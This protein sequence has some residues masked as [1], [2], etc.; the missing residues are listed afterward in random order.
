MVKI[1]AITFDI[2]TTLT[3]GTSWTIITKKLGAPVKTHEFIYQELKDNKISY[4]QAKGQLLNLWKATGNNNKDFFTKIFR[5]IPL[6]KGAQEIITYLKTKGII[7]CLIT[8]SVDLYAETIAK[9]LGIDHYF[10]NTELVWD[11]NN[12]LVDFHYDINQSAKKLQ[13]F[14]HFLSQQKIN[15]NDCFIVGDDEN[16]IDLFK[17]TKK[18]IA[19]KSEKIDR[20]K[21]YAWKVINNLLDIKKIV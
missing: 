5:N 1:K 19:V 3:Y 4:Q 12:K 20:L 16:D 6:K 18:G 11:K 15:T 17:F 21:P 13:Q 2:D 9:R 7:I 14:L 10:A 8:G